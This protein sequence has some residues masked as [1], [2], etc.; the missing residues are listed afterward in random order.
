[1]NLIVSHHPYPSAWHVTRL[2]DRGRTTED[3]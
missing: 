2:D 3:G 1:V